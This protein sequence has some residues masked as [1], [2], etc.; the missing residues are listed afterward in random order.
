[1]FH[2][3]SALWVPCCAMDRLKSAFEELQASWRA[4]RDQRASVDGGLAWSADAVDA[5]L[6]RVVLSFAAVGIDLRADPAVDWVS[7]VN[8]V[9]RGD[10]VADGAV[11]VSSPPVSMEVF[12][13]PPDALPDWP[14]PADRSRC[15]RDGGRAAEALQS[16]CSLQD[17]QFEVAAVFRRYERSA[18]LHLRHLHSEAYRKTLYFYVDFDLFV[19][20]LQRGPVTDDDL[21]WYRHKFAEWVLMM[22]PNDRRG[23]GEDVRVTME[24][25]GLYV[26]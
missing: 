19:K 4:L 26:D 16:V 14:W 18:V 7:F 21:V 15:H 23:F 10:V 2:S 5:D 1:M 3:S 22:P 8:S 17:V 11:R 13:E 9:G 6:K 24:V 25:P 12:I 20:L